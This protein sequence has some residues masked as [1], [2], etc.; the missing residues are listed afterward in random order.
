MLTSEFSSTYA[1]SIAPAKIILKAGIGE[2][3]VREM[4]AQGLEAA[5]GA[6][7]RL[8]RFDSKPTKS[9]SQ[10]LEQRPEFI[11]SLTTGAN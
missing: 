11:G 4:L 10:V 3:A 1:A 2:E 5:K 9:K 6:R 7:S 8:T